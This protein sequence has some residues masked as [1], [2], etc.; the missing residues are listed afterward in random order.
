MLERGYRG[1]Q[2][3]QF[4]PA[5]H[6]PRVMFRW[7]LVILSFAGAV[8][9][10]TFGGYTFLRGSRNER[11]ARVSL[12]NR[13]VK[14]WSSGARNQLLPLSLT[15]SVGGGVWH[16][17]TPSTKPDTL[18]DDIT[19]DLIEY[20]PLKLARTGALVPKLAWDAAGVKHESVHLRLK[21]KNGVVSE[22]AV[23]HVLF[24]DT[25]VYPGTNPKN[26]MYQ[27]HGYWNPA[28]ASCQAYRVPAPLPHPQ[29][30][31]RTS[32]LCMAISP[33]GATGHWRL[34]AQ[35][36]GGAG[37]YQGTGNASLVRQVVMPG[38]SNLYANG[39][40]PSGL[41]DYSDLITTVRTGADPWLQAERITQG[42]LQFGPS[43]RDDYLQGGSFVALGALL[44]MPSIVLC[45]ATWKEP[46]DEYQR[47]IDEK[48]EL[49]NGCSGK[50]A[51][52]W[53][54]VSQQLSA[55]PQVQEDFDGL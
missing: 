7:V 54:R 40:P 13:A 22:L 28:T 42:T 27:M 48:S 37:C 31:Q 36:E 51:R 41:L 55:S 26:C 47:A 43:Q 34:R 53:C 32:E 2:H 30:L 1:G 33:V 6:S 39:K 5:S 25:I 49:T 4:A 52:V 44:A 18:A 23:G 17:L 21:N 46:H 11:H 19:E 15:L 38:A 3:S 35:R 16:T 14:E 50:L 20:Q 29:C 8:G 45:V 24:Y 12:Y 9:C 10:L